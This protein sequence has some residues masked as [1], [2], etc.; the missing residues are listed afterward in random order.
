MLSATD[1]GGS[2]TGNTGRAEQLRCHARC[3]VKHSQHHSDMMR[4]E[5]L[6]THTGPSQC[7]A[8]PHSARYPQCITARLQRYLQRR[9]RVARRAAQHAASAASSCARTRRH[10]PGLAL[11]AQ[12]LPRLPTGTLSQAHLAPGQHQRAGCCKTW[13]TGGAADCGCTHARLA[14]RRCHDGYG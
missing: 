1:S 13:H 6:L 7:S 12:Y 11:D 8:Y 9:S 2:A 4:H 5:L 14:E 3:W 10:S